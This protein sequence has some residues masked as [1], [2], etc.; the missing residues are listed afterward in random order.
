V[1]GV[2]DLVCLDLNPP[3]GGAVGQV[4][5]VLHE[6][7]DRTVLAA[8]LAAWLDGFA[9]DLESKKYLAKH[10]LF[11]GLVHVRDLGPNGMS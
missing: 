10:E 9:T 7:G 4:I 5:E 2:G 11:N 3:K 6:D 8:S 1:N